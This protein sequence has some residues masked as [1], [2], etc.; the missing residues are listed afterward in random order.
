M[1]TKYC[2]GCDSVKTVDQ[3]YF[4]RESGKP[5]KYCKACKLERQKK[6]Q[7]RLAKDSGVPH[8]QDIIDKLKSMGIY[9]CSGKKSR[10]RWVDIVAF[11]CVAIEAKLGRKKNNTYLFTFTSKQVR[12]GI[13]GDV[14]IFMIDEGDHTQYYIFGRDEPVLYDMDGQLKRW[15]SYTP[16]SGHGN[17]S[18]D[19]VEMMDQAEGNWQLII[20]VFNQKLQ[21]LK[22]GQDVD[23]WASI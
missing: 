8:E 5:E 16:E 13:R 12:H 4:H 3:F 21:Q 9:A 20:D 18:I 7:R 15:V 2:V 1:D 23:A 14:V 10:S 11:G 22:R 17:I 6:Y 19:M